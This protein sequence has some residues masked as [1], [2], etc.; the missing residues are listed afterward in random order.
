MLLAQFVGD[1]FV[2]EADKL[3]EWSV[4]PTSATRQRWNELGTRRAN[5][6][7]VI[8]IV[9]RMFR[10]GGRRGRCICPDY[11]RACVTINAAEVDVPK[12]Q[13]KL[14]RQPG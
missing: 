4:W 14:Q 11:D 2:G 9:R 7:I 1:A 8:S 10:G 12:R 13:G 3:G 6:A 5:G